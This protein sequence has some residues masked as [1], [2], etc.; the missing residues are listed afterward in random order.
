MNFQEDRPSSNVT[1]PGPIP[2]IVN[3]T[4]LQVLR[5]PDGVFQVVPG[6]AP[7]IACF[8]DVE[9]SASST[10]EIGT[11]TDWNLDFS[12]RRRRS[13]QEDLD[14]RLD[15]LEEENEKLRL[16]VI[17][18]EAAQIDAERLQRRIEEQDDHVRQLHEA[19][20]ELGFLTEEKKSLQATLHL[21]QEELLASEQRAR[22]S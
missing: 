15:I 17:N 22:K 14:E 20:E 11:Q 18:L 4:D 2:I 5:T 9:T 8:S 16:K 19:R 10:Q 1:S 12:C 7:G 3:F 6:A 13:S 21:L